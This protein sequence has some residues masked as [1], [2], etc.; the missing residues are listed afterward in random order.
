[1]NSTGYVAIGFRPPGKE[2]HTIMKFIISNNHYITDVTASCRGEAP[3][4]YA[5]GEYD[6]S[7]HHTSL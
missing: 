1:M 3:G 4:S 6:L 7:V 5:V 2:K